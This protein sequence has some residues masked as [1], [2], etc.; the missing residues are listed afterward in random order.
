MS[1]LPGLPDTSRQLFPDDGFRRLTAATGKP[2][3]QHA[4]GD[5]AVVQGFSR[6]LKNLVC[7]L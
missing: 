7:S 4:T 2:L 3:L 6:V 5:V 1:I